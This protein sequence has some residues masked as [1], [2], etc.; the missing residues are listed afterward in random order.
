MMTFSSF[1]VVDGFVCESFFWIFA[2]FFVV[3][4]VDIEMMKKRRMR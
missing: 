4:G 1:F 3:V 2:S